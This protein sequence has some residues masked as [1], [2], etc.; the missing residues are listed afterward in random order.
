[1]GEGSSVRGDTVIGDGFEELEEVSGDSGGIPRKFCGRNG[2]QPLLW[3]RDPWDLITVLLDCRK[4]YEW[5]RVQ[6][7]R[8]PNNLMF[9]TLLAAPNMLSR[10]FA[11]A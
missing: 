6:M 9:V 4:R 3:Y 10:V 7:E 8:R 11:V 1:M 2:G 5:T